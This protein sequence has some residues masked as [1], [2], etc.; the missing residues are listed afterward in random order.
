MTQGTVSTGE[1]VHIDSPQGTVR[2]E[3]IDVPR[4]G[5]VCRFLGIPYAE[6][7]RGRS[8]WQAPVAKES[9]P[10]DFPALQAGA[11]ASQLINADAIPGLWGAYSHLPAP[12]GDD[13]LS[14]NVWSPEAAC[15]GDGSGRPVMVWVHGG[16]WLTGAGSASLYAGEE[17]AAVEDVVVVTLNYRLGAF[18]FSPLARMSDGAM[19]GT[20]CEGVLDQIEALR[21]VQR[22]IAAYGG[23]PDNVTIWGQSAGGGCVSTLMSVRAAQGLFHKA[24]IHSNANA[25]QPYE[26][27]ISR[28]EV[29]LRQIDKSVPRALE[30]LADLSTSEIQANI[31]AV[32]PLIPEDLNGPLGDC[33]FQPVIG[34]D[35]DLVTDY[36]LN[37]L[38]RQSASTVPV[39]AGS[40]Y[41]DMSIMAA[42]VPTLKDIAAAD[43]HPNLG[44]SLRG[45]VG[46]QLIEA[47]TEARS[48]RDLPV[49]PYALWEAI[50]SDQCHRMPAV[51]VLEEQQ[52]AGAETYEFVFSAGYSDP[53]LPPWVGASHG[54]ELPMCFGSFA[55]CSGVEVSDNMLQL[56]ERVMRAWAAFARH[57]DPSTD[58]LGEWPCYGT[59]RNTMLIDYQQSKVVQD[60]HG[61]ERQAWTHV[62]NDSV[63]TFR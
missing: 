1:P 51:R 32:V 23:D 49:T 57:G 43:L 12:I 22:N 3:R 16:G 30:L 42:F 38:G 63:G 58:G 47:Y 26:L 31:N 37:V 14:L 46:Q 4:G 36:P 56:S 15:K 10:D 9:L 33:P 11:V 50:R 35:P 21:W 6:P 45:P 13:C 60:H 41:N 61:P 2:G 34:D 52:R 24:I 62:P 27:A 5:C 59:E 18:G 17:L 48:E 8:R 40:T 53:G 54:M 25:V 44:T 7:L 39:L 28:T 19:P 55:A 20:G 29:W